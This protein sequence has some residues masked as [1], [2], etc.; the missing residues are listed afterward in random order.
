MAYKKHEIVPFTGAGKAI[1][2]RGN[3]C[4]VYKAVIKNGKRDGAY[5]QW[6]C[7]GK[8]LLKTSYK[9]NKEVGKHESWDD[10]GLKL[11]E[12][13]FD[14]NGKEVNGWRKNF[15]DGVLLT[16]IKWVDGKKNGLEKFNQQYKCKQGIDEIGY[17]KFK[18]GEYIGCAKKINIDEDKIEEDKCVELEKKFEAVLSIDH[19]ANIVCFK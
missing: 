3:K 6:T 13:I 4:Y 17:A 14:N 8:L 2:H 9:N 19:E 15:Y 11:S 18:D 12:I 1:V 16:N 10:S 5:E 7:N